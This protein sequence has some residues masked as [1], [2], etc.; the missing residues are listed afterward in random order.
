MADAKKVLFREPVAGRDGVWLQDAPHNLMVI[1]SV[2]TVDRLEREVLRDL[3]DERVMKAGGGSRYARFSR[4]IVYRGERAFWQ[5]D[6]AFDIDRHIVLAPPLAEDPLALASREK[7]QVYVGEQAS[8]PLPADR[9]LWQLQVVPDYRDGKS[10][11]IVRIHHVMGDGVSLVP[12]L[13]SLMDPEKGGEKT[14][15][16]AGKKATAWHVTAAVLAGPFLLAQ[17]FSWRRDRSVVHGPALSGTKR[18][19]W[20]DPIEVDLI[21]KVKNTLGATVNDVLMACVSSAFE[22]YVARRGGAPMRKLRVSMPVN[23]RPLEEEPRM[24]NK[25]AAV[26]LDLPVG[27]ADL[28]ARVAAT[29][30]RLDALKRSPEP[31][32]TYGTVR[33]LLKTLPAGLS[34]FLIDFLANKC[35]CVVSNVPGPPSPVY[36]AGRRV[37]AMMFWVPQRSGI[38]IGISMLSFTGELMVGA[39]CDTEVVDDPRL[40]MECF[41]D[42]FRSLRESVEL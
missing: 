5:D 16:V 22:R 41:S 35:T 18:V 26:M 7:L 9:P 3:W 36:L 38:G 32:F 6:P 4:K 19:A 34:R 33:L 17:K 15:P 42:E 1:N 31:L 13:F 37:R 8:R 40:F 25:F 12:I 27:F 30:R 39:I 14:L 23:L 11:V 29:K 28:R 21:K 24:E 2:F 10:A 20:T